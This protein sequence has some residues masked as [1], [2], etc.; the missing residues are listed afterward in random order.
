MINRIRRYTL[1]L[2]LKSSSEVN[3]FLV[4][5]SF[6]TWSSSA[7]RWHDGD[8]RQHAHDDAEDDAVRGVR[9]VRERLGAYLLNQGVAGEGGRW[10]MYFGGMSSENQQSVGHHFAKLDIE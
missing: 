5:K 1:L 10:S 9:E 7:L 8:E 3:A 6:G 4:L 2:V